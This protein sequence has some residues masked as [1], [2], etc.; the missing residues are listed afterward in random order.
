MSSEVHQ[1]CHTE[2]VPASSAGWMELTHNGRAS[3]KPDCLTLS[4]KKRTQSS[5]K[6]LGGGAAPFSCK[7]PA[8]WGASTEDGMAAVLCSSVHT[9]TAD[10]QGSCSA[11]VRTPAGSLMD[12]HPSLSFGTPTPPLQQ[13]FHTALMDHNLTA[14]QF[15]VPNSKTKSSYVPLA[16]QSLAWP[17]TVGALKFLFC[18]KRA[19]SKLAIFPSYE[20][21]LVLGWR[22]LLLWEAADAE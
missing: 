17:E 6:S 5:F 22:T 4:S 20:R 9:P 18:C 19:N 12:L 16:H 8:Q 10:G 11:L 15:T 3:N 2:G 7:H 1:Q 21:T 13:R 14:R